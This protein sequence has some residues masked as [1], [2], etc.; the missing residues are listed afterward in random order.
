[1]SKKHFKFAANCIIEIM[2]QNNFSFASLEQME[3]YK[4]YVIFFTRYSKDF[5]INK[6]KYYILK[7]Y[8]K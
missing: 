6:F 3:V 8:N 1:M 7:N 4:Q 5:A 2:R